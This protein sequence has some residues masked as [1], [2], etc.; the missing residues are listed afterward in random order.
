MA[1][2]YLLGFSLLINILILVIYY[3][4]KRTNLFENK[5][6]I[7][8]IVCNI[9]CLVLEV[10]CN[11]CASEILKI[12]KNIIVRMFLSGLLFFGCLL[13]VYTTLICTKKIDKYNKIL[14]TFLTTFVIFNIPLLFLPL[15]FIEYNSLYYADGMAIRYLVAIALIYICLNFVMITK[16][17]KKLKKKLFPPLIYMLLM[18]IGIYIHNLDP[19]ISEMNTLETFVCLIMYFTIE[20]PDLQMI[21]QLEIA[22]EQSE[23]ANR[24]KSD[25]LSSMSHEI[26]TPLNA[27]IGFSEDIQSKKTI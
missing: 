19:T 1:N 27:I 18:F 22:N 13:S 9:V 14:S 3:R 5:V 20:N 12:D 6:Y 26:R 21:Q 17:F 11:L 24:A 4:K 7:A 23:K 2:Y 25:F 10:L 8:I 16:Y 15:N